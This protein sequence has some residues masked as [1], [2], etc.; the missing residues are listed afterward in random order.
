MRTE[1]L[2]ALQGL[3]KATLGTFTV[4]TDLPWESDGTPLYVKN[5]KRIYVD[6]EDSDLDPIIDTLDG[7]GFAH[8]VVSLTVNY[9]C[10]AKTLPSNFN[11]LND[12]VQNL[13]LDFRNEGW[14]QRRVNKTTELDADIIVVSQE[15]TFER[16]VNN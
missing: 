14:Q 7:F 5:L 16:I 11:T 2:T 10:D 6:S 3:T 12:A 15:F 13:R 1:L 9:A 8:E 4:V